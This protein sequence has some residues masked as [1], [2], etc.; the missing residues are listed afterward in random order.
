MKLAVS[1]INGKKSV[2]KGE[3]AALQAISPF[4]TVFSKDLCCRYVGKKKTGLVWERVKTFF[5]NMVGNLFKTLGKLFFS[6]TGRKP[7]SYCHG[8][9]SVVCLSV[10]PCVRA[11]VNSSFKKLLLRNY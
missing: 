8:I 7:A 3:I 1:S 9:V 11:S 5:L 10:C 2:R 6:S 4:P